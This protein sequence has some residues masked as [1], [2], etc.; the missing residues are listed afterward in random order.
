MQKALSQFGDISGTRLAIPERMLAATPLSAWRIRRSLR[1][2]EAACVAAGG[3]GMPP[4][5]DAVSRCAGL[6]RL[7]GCPF[8]HQESGDDRRGRRV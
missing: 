7:P 5:V 1:W 6:I 8:P 4:V 3:R 2:A